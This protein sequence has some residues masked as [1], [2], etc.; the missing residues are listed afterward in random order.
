MGLACA[1]DQLYSVFSFFS[2]RI[3]IKKKHLY[4]NHWRRFYGNFFKSVTV[5][6]ANSLFLFDQKYTIYNYIILFQNHVEFMIYYF[7]FV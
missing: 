7:C 5:D 1:H 4:E 3:N 6:A 2:F